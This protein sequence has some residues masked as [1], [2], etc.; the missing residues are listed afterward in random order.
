MSTFNVFHPSNPGAP[1]KSNVQIKVQS[2]ISPASIKYFPFQDLWHL[3][4]LDTFKQ[5]WKEQTLE[6]GG[7]SLDRQK[8]RISKNS[9][10]SFK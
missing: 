9:S 6:R 4:C 1:M 2:K 3:R 10:G 7:S 5:G 8:V